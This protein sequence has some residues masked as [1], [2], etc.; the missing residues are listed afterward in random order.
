MKKMGDVNSRR[1][2][3]K[4]VKKVDGRLRLKREESKCA[5]LG[6]GAKSLTRS[7]FGLCICMGVFEEGASGNLHVLWRGDV[8]DRRSMCFVTY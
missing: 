8:R 3:R 1:V 6:E 7:F 2:E 4:R 5:L